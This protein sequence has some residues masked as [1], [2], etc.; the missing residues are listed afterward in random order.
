MTEDLWPKTR[1]CLQFNSQKTMLSASVLS[2]FKSPD[3]KNRY[4][5][6]DFP[7]AQRALAALESRPVFDDGLTS[8][9]LR[10]L[11]QFLQK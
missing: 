5:L 11:S 7:A 1:W 2:P 10:T 3:K 6:K 9:P 4:P 8:T